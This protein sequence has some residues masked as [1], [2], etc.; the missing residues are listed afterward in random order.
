[1][2]YV[3]SRAY[4]LSLTHDE[5]LTFTIVEGLPAWSHTANHH[6]L[7]TFLVRLSSWFFGSSEVALRLPN[8]LS[9]I[10]Y[11]YGL[12]VIL[13]PFNSIWLSAL[14]YCVFLLNP[15]I[16]EFFSLARGYGISL[17]CMLLSLGFFLRNASDV[18]GESYY[19]NSYYALVLAVSAMLAN[20]AMINYLIALCLVVLGQFYLKFKQQIWSGRLCRL[21]FWGLVSVVSFSLYIG[22]SRLLFLKKHGQLYF[23]ADGVFE[24]LR[25]LVVSL[26]YIDLPEMIINVST[27]LLLALFLF[28]LGHLLYRRRFTSEIAGL[29][30][31]TGLLFLGLFFEN[32]VFGAKFPMERSALVLVPL[33]GLLLCFSLHQL[34]LALPLGRIPALSVVLFAGV[35]FLAGVNLS[36]SKTWK[37]DARTKHAM[38]L[39]SKELES[40]GE[41]ATISNHWLFEPAINYYIDRWAIGLASANRDGPRADTDFILTKERSKV[42]EGYEVLQS[43]DDIGTILLG[44]K[45]R[46]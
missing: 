9:L 22:V 2:G 26:L 30:M 5:A 24:M 37:Y 4:L 33:F 16:L 44:K 38:L 40:A 13:K 34:I 1:M 3:V 36:H 15:F 7:N 35:N 32:L 14:G 45:Q 19:R 31:I 27:F 39:V 43:Y 42:F 8:V 17:G 29:L 25:S 46:M 23:G 21:S 12:H 6:L 10:P 28:A 18:G 20:L 41:E 11:I